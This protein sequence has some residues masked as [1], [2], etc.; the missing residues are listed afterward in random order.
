MIDD[1]LDLIFPKRKVYFPPSLRA[2]LQKDALRIVD[3]GGAMGPDERWKFL[4]LELCRFVTFEPD[5]RSFGGLAIDSTG[6]NASLAVG[7]SNKAGE[8][9]LYLTH[10]EFA[11]SLYR[12]NASVLKDYATWPWHESAGETKIPVDTLN[13]AL[14]AHK[15]WWPD[16]IKVDVE[17][18]D[19]DVLKGATDCLPGAF[20][21]QV[22]VA[23]VDRNVGAPLQPEIDGWLRAAGFIPQ[24]VIREHWIRNNGI[25]GATSRPQ[26]IWAD[27]VYVRDR[28]WS[29]ARL[30]QAASTDRAAILTKMIAVLLA[31]GAHDYAMELVEAAASA[32]YVSSKESVDLREAVTGSVISVPAFVVRGTVALILA[33]L[34]GAVLLPFGSKF[35]AV[36]RQIAAKQAVPLF[37]ALYR[38]AS[39]TGLQAS[40]IADLP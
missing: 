37:F 29:L 9:T 35:R 36:G 10:G 14:A 13:H 31:Y 32:G 34:V 30:E 28:S 39:R 11:S 20:G 7:L 12:P 4:G 8:Q 38:S 19:L 26:I 22:E 27:V 6:R 16:F 17:G 3:V 40:C 23:F 21:V 24:Q 1:N 5:A 25:Y 33:L 2:L 15:D 18:A